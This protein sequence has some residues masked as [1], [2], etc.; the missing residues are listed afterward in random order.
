MSQALRATTQPLSPERA[1][2]VL[3]VEDDVGLQRLVAGQLSSLQVK[4]TLCRLGREAVVHARQEHF[5]VVLL[6]IGLPDIDGLEVLKRLLDQ[7]ED[8]PVVMLTA[9][10]SLEVAVQA[11]QIG[12]FDYLQKP[13]SIERLHN[14]IRNAS[15]KRDLENQ[16]K[17]LK[18]APPSSVRLGMVGAAPA[19]QDLFDSIERVGVSDV[20][21]A[22]HG[23]S[24][25]GKELAAR[26]LHRCSGRKMQNFV[27]LNC[28]AIAESLQESELFGHEK[29]AFT[30]AEK[31]RI[32]RFE[33]A[34]KGTL[35]L[36][37]IAE[38]S[39]SLQAKLLR[40]IQ[41]RSFSRVGGQQLI[42]SDFRLITATHKN[43]EEEVAAG[44]FREDLYYRIAV[45]ELELPSLRERREDIPLIAGHLLDH[46]SKAQNRRFFLSPDA[47]ELLS[48]YDWPG[49]VRELQNAIQHAVVVSSSDR[50]ETD[51][52]PA[53]VWRS[54]HQ[55]ASVPPPAPPSTGSSDQPAAAA[56]DWDSAVPTTLDAPALPRVPPRSLA[57]P[58]KLST[59]NIEELYELAIRQAM[60]EAN[61]N[62]SEVIRRTGIGRTSMYRRL[63]EY[64]LR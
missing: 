58:I 20:S 56:A 7:E 50:I 55:P 29:G 26:A 2:S 35:F 59:C 9:N 38:L 48:E 27:A 47:A 41:E 60:E 31:K 61:G 24:G 42:E 25:S 39:L 17:R 53:R 13:V 18:E 19:M 5:D 4:S 11:T 45:F 15:G 8:L 40:V 30:G 28:A 3:I 43:L 54:F 46:L 23:E 22:I 52:L 36:D 16:V 14:V 49:N 12:A 64:G 57:S 37:E 21:V 33:E 44:R 63:R 1:H 62:V 10:D 34:N 6:D 32:G 51:A